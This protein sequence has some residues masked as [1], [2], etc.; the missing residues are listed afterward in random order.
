MLSGDTS[1][2]I[3]ATEIDKYVLE[4]GN[5]ETVFF[6]GSVQKMSRERQRDKKKEKRMTS[7]TK[8]TKNSCWYQQ[9]LPNVGILT[10]V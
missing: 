9:F 2:L 10:S 4:R 3:K 5:S 7:R 6:G 8:L 1:E